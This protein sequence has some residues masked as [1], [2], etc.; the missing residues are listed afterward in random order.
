MLN[1]EQHG[2]VPKIRRAIN[3]FAQ[4]H[5]N[6]SMSLKEGRAHFLTDRKNPIPY[7]FAGMGRHLT[8]SKCIEP[9]PFSGLS[10]QLVAHLI[11]GTSLECSKFNA[12]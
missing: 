3:N 10:G 2:N 12:L 9:Y 7:T 6:N 1:F 4:T 5:K 11:F 8:Q